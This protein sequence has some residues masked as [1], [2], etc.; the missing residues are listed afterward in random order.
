MIN[1][2]NCF[3]VN[4]GYNGEIPLPTIRIPNDFSSTLKQFELGNSYKC[5]FVFVGG[6]YVENMKDIVDIVDDIAMQF[7]GIKP[8]AMFVMGKFNSFQI[9]NF[10]SH[11]QELTKV[12]TETF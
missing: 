1:N 9:E 8:I 5:Y 2:R 3:G 4:F 11:G 10:S 7:N 12:L 6:K